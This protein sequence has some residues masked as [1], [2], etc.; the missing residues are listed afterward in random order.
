MKRSC[1]VLLLCALLLTGCGVEPT[2]IVNDVEKD[3]PIR[4]VATIQS[5][6]PITAAPA[7]G[8]PV[9]TLPPTK[10][11]T[12]APT[13]TP[14]PTATP[15]P[16]AAPTDGPEL[17]QTSVPTAVASPTPDVSKGEQLVMIAQQYINYPYTRGGQSPDKGFDP[18]GFVCWCLREMGLKVK[19]RTSA[20][21]AEEESWTK[22]TRMSELEPGDLV[23]FRTGDN[24]NI[25]CVCIYLGD[26]RMIYPST[27]KECVI[28]TEINSYWTN[29]FQWARRVF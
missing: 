12:P 6:S 25:N 7:T 17:Q 4:I 22:I 2:H 16:T 11:P 15:R 24:E 5:S 9:V 28:V 20:G 21:Y 3:E 18:S 1:C 26:S 10:A 19:R 29:A 13:D 23:F 27:S 14:A 8:T